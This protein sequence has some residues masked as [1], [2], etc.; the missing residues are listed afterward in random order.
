MQT[1]IDPE[2]VKTRQ[3][4]L[5]GLGLGGGFAVMLEGYSNVQGA[6]GNFGDANHALEHIGFMAFQHGVSSLGRDIFQ[7]GNTDPVVTHEPYGIPFCAGFTQKPLFFAGMASYNGWDPT[8]LR[9]SSDV[10]TTEAHVFC[11]EET[12]TDEEANHVGEVVSYLAIE[13]NGAHKIRAFAQAPPSTGVDAAN[14]DCQAEATVDDGHC[15]GCDPSDTACSA[16]ASCLPKRANDDG[17]ENLQTFGPS[18]IATIDQLQA[19]GWTWPANEPINDFG[20]CSGPTGSTRETDGG[21]ACACTDT[22]PAG[23]EYAGF[24]CGGSCTGTQQLSLPAGY[25]T[26]KLTIGMHYNNPVCRGLITVNGRT[27]L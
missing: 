11:Q 17:W 16:G 8:Q 22:A 10:T 14:Q 1:T 4:P 21:C 25:N 23:E 2:F 20:A 9:M 19:A 12:C 3:K 5:R 6:N 27:V 18:N 7:A 26:I 15:I 13:H 24:W